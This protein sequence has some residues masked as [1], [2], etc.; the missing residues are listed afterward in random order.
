MSID[1]Q[2]MAREIDRLH[3]FFR[4]SGDDRYLDHAA[5]AFEDLAEDVREQARRPGT[6]AASSPTSSNSSRISERSW[7]KATPR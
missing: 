5:Y 4:F 2:A 7:H 6:S 1:H 3:L